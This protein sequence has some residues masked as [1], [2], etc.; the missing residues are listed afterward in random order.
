MLLAVFWGCAHGI[1]RS[2]VFFRF[3]FSEISK[4]NFFN[5]TICKLKSLV[6]G[7]FCFFLVIL[8]LGST[9]DHPVDVVGFVVVQ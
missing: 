5:L 7:D 9:W 2:F 3:F 6:T 4:L 1:P 8:L